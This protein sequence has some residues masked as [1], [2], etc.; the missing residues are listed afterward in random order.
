MALTLTRRQMEE[1]FTGVFDPG[2]TRVLVEVFD[3]IREAEIERAADT[4]DLKQGLIELTEAQRHT[5][6]TVA[7]LSH[8]VDR[9]GKSVGELTAAQQHTDESVAKLFTGLD[10][11]RQE[12][13]GL[14]N[15]FGFS[16]EEF[17]AALLPPYLQRY[18]DISDLV[19][20]RRYFDIGSGQMEEVD[21]VG[22][23][24]RNDKPITVLAEC[25]AKIGGDELRRLATKLSGVAS[26][27]EMGEVL[28]VVVAMNV[29]PTAEQAGEETGVLVVPYSRINRNRG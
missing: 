11:L 13:G 2:Q 9:L 18:E 17:V 16:L 24:Q 14:A 21:L 27:I 6:E 20:E 8:S 25:R 29:H 28:P 5:D 26:T 12:V 7:K 23:G 10:L 22:E 19:L 4:R 15:R 1:K 3:R